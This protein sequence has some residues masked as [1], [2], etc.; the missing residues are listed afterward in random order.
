[1][2][3]N[4]VKKSYRDLIGRTELIQ[5]IVS[6]PDTRPAANVSGFSR[7]DMQARRQRRE[8]RMSRMVQHAGSGW[9]VRTW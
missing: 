2:L 1:M 9:T 7:S 4:S 5:P 8:R 3:I 6:V